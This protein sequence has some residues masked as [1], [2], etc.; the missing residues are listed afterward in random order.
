M[1]IIPQ[2]VHIEI[3]RRN[4]T[5]YKKQG[6]NDI[7][8]GDIIS[9]DVN[10]LSWGCQTKVAVRCDYCGDTVMVKYRDYTH[11]KFDKYSCKH[12]R[13]KKT[14]EYNLAERQENLYKR[15][16]DF[17]NKMNY[18]LITKKSDI[19]NAE[20]RALYRCPKHGIHETKIYTLISGHICIDC[21]IEENGMKSRKSIEDV[22]ND[23]KKYGG[24][25]LNKEDYLGW[26]VKNLKVVCSECGEIFITS[27]CAFMQ[28]EGQLCSKCTSSMSRGEQEVKKYLE[29]NNMQFYTQFRFDDCRNIAALPFDF[30][31]PDY[32]ICIEY[33]GEGHFIPIRR[34]KMSDLEALELLENIKFRDE[35]KTSYCDK[36]LIHL[37]RIPYWEFNNIKDILNKELFT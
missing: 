24:E 11:Y 9:I 1:L 21:S 33:D 29:E 23:F 19:L 36:N 34:G 7:K 37:I 10:D 5:H 35:I 13:Q 27:Y 3:T 18:E 22:Y 8:I 30:Y 14:S 17:C 2:N 25:L 20:S 6:Y 31:L 4:I 26:N 16:L 12:C 28:H 15:A 32:N